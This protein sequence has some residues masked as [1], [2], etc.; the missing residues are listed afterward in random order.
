[1]GLPGSHVLHKTQVLEGLG[2]EAG[3]AKCTLTLS[4]RQFLMGPGAS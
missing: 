1:M 3:S 4:I 2:L